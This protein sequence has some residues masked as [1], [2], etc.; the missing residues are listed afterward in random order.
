MSPSRKVTGKKLLYR[1]VLLFLMCVP[2]SQLLFPTLK[3]LHNSV[4]SCD[5]MSLQFFL[6][7]FSFCASM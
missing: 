6:V 1:D 2:M 4:L 7:C 5:F 3:I